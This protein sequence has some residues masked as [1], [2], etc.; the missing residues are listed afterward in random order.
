ALAAQSLPRPNPP[1]LPGPPPPPPDTPTPRPPQ[2]ARPPRSRR[3]PRAARAGPRAS[4]P[5]AAPPGRSVP[6]GGAQRRNT[7]RSWR[8]WAGGVALQR[9]PPIGVSTFEQY[10]LLAGGTWARRSPAFGRPTG[11]ARAT[12]RSGRVWGDTPDR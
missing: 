7:S 12:S 3:A 11:K 5:P 10:G 8:R 1:T 9:E 6:R 4:R 2:T